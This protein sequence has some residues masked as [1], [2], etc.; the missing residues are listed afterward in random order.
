MGTRFLNLNANPSESAYCDRM[1]II[2]FYERIS[3]GEYLMR[4][5]CY[6]DTITGKVCMIDLNLNEK[7]LQNFDDYKIIEIE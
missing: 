4:C 1:W 3:S 5:D 6:I 2:K 7:K